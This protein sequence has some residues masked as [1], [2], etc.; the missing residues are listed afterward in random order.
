MF[1]VYMWGVVEGDGGIFCGTGS[2]QKWA[3]LKCMPARAPAG[4]VDPGF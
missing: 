1:E 3:P 4:C 2:V